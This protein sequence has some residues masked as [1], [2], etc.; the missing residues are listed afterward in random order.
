[1][2]KFTLTPQVWIDVLNPNHSWSDPDTKEPKFIKRRVDSGNGM[3]FYHE[4]TLAD[5]IARHPDTEFKV[6][7]T[8]EIPYIRHTSTVVEHTAQV[9]FI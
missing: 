7:Q 9:L 2:R 3:A 1:M 5:H 8:I 6:E 4:G